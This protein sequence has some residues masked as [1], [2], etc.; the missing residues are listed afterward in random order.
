MCRSMVNIQS[1]AAEI[2]RGKK[3]KKIDDRNHRAK[4]VWSALLHRATI[5]SHPGQLSLGPS[6]GW[7]VSTGKSAV[8]LCGSGVKAGWFTPLAGARVGGR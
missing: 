3:K 7:D 6:A 8:V 4:I 2:R 5:T 1:A